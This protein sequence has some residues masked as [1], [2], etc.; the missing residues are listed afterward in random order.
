MGMAVVDY[1]VHQSTISTT[2]SKRKL[3][4]FTDQPQQTPPTSE[5]I[6]KEKKAI[7]SKDVAEA[8]RS[9]DIAKE[10][11][12]VLKQ[13][14]SHDLLSSSP[15]FHGDLPAHVNKSKL[16]GEIEPGLELTTWSR[17]SP[18]ATGQGVS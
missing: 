18:L 2:I 17:E 6:L 8:Q 5:A 7:S 10:R 9:M 16:I 4:M 14:L 12:M 15:K 3:P 13:I 11:G 1:I